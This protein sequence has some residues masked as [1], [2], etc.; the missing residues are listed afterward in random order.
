[1]RSGLGLTPAP[2]LSAQN[3][4]VARNLN[5]L[6]QIGAQTGFGGGAGL[7]G[8]GFGGGAGLGGTG[9]GGVQPTLSQA[10]QVGLQSGAGNFGLGQ[11]NAGNGTLFGN[12]GRTNSVYQPLLPLL[13][14]PQGSYLG[15]GV[16]GQPEAYVNNQPLRNFFRY[17]L[18]F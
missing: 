17:L 3:F 7:G 18:P 8:A 4:N 15:Q 2:N 10:P 5:P 6:P 9:F 11:F 1:M 13:R 14:M 16:I 12:S